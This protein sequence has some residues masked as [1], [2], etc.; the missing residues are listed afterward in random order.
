MRRVIF[1]GYD[2]EGVGGVQNLFVGF[3]KEFSRIGIETVVLC[4]ENSFIYKNIQ[5][6]SSYIK[7]VNTTK[8]KSKYW[9]DY[10]SEED[11]LIV[12]NFT[13]NLRPFIKRNPYVIFWVVLP[14]VF[15]KANEIKIYSNKQRTVK[16]INY[17]NENN[18][19][20]FMDKSCLDSVE[21]DYSIKLKEPQYLSIPVNI[22]KG[23][24]ITKSEKNS[25]KI[26]VT[27]LGRGEVLWKIYPVKKI[28]LDLEACNLDIEIDFYIITNT[29]ELF[30]KELSL[31]NRSKV[32]I[33]Y[34]LDLNG[35]KLSKFIA[36]H[37]DIHFA[38]G[39]SALESAK[40]YI[41]T[42]VM[43]ASNKDFPSAYSYKW[44]HENTCYE[45]GT[46][47]DKYA[48]GKESRKSIGEV[49]EELL[50]NKKQLGLLARDYV[51]RN[52]SLDLNSIK[53]LERTKISQSRLSIFLEFT[54]RQNYFFQLLRRIFKS[55]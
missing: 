31:I 27:Y 33:F 47:I 19:L 34:K 37:S 49:L 38:M 6:L 11:V 18:G 28:L 50:K 24:T 4:K 55:C 53:L 43:D 26:I 51:E 41:P 30:E 29:K 22:S 16:L 39:T 7:I 1:Y 44:L 14:G 54:L 20:I 3:I 2:Q 15:N 45:L 35:E 48:Y 25:N 42:I 5:G 12:A 40:L 17:L 21:Q 13:S 32:N 9:S 23:I 36:S 46:F 10:I 8:I 52:H